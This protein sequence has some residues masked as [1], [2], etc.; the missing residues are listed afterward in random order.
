[1]ILKPLL[2]A[3]T[4]ALLLSGPALAAGSDDSAPPQPTETTQVCERGQVFDKK[5]KSCLDA[6]SETFTDDDRYHAAREMAYAGEY[7]HAL[8]VLATA[9]NPENPRI[10][11]Y[12]G[13][14]NRKAGNGEVAMEF[15]ARALAIDPDYILARSYMGQGLV[16]EGDL[17]GAKAQLAEIKARGGTESWAYASLAKAI[18]GQSSDW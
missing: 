18:N 17:A 15:Y 4:F 10:L 2:T 11:N 14:A 7:H 9:D 1:M 3:A 5:T 13:F 8:M 6:K 12:T 16:A